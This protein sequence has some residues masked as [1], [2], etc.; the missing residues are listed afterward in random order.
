MARRDIA[1]EIVIMIGAVLDRGL[2]RT[3]KC[4]KSVPKLELRWDIREEKEM[5]TIGAP[6]E[7]MESLLKYMN[8]A[9]GY[10]Y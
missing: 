7:C 9:E 3:G 5:R 10:I 2:I 6:L 1:E 4:A 8:A